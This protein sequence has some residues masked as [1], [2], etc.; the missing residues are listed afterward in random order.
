MPENTV[1]PPEKVLCQGNENGPG[2]QW[3][4]VKDRVCVHDSRRWYIRSGKK[5]GARPVA[6]PQEHSTIDIAID[7]TL[8]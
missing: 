4:I 3:E 7:S 1:Q 6:A 5:K 8:A 2:V